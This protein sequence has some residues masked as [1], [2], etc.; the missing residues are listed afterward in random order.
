MKIILVTNK[1]YRG[2]LDAGWWYFYLPLIEMGH[3]VYLYD[4]VSPEEKDFNKVVEALKPNL[5]FCMM[6]GDPNITP[7]EPWA[8]I[9]SETISGRTKTF[10]WFC[11]DTWRYESFSKKAC[12]YF[13]VCST[14]EPDYILRYQKAGYDNIILG[15][16]HSNINL[17]PKIQYRDKN[18][19]VSFIGALNGL[20]KNFFNLHKDLPIEI[21][22]NLS[23]EEMYSTHTK[24]KIA[25]NLSINENDPFMKTQMKQRMFEIPA[26]KTL[27]L[28][29]YHPAIEEFFKVD[30]EIITFKSNKEFSD[31]VKFLNS[32]PKIVE[33]ITLAG[34]KRFIAEHESKVR[35]T[36]VLQHIMAQ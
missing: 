4:T 32:R 16:W 20:R 11:D 24:S 6:T 12:Q 28:T 31:K 14:P 25:I 23:Q 7:H 1:T 3:E 27:L 13:N 2:H 26:A 9:R 8:Q 21:F 34:F 15:S 30:K 29:E 36:K 33:A 22:S 19:D 17:Y 10:N 5:I 18:I 35:L